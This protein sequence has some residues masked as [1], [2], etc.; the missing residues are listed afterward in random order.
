MIDLQYDRILTGEMVQ[1]LIALSVLAGDPNL[2]SSTHV[3]T[4][5]HS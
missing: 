1:W 3:V 2:V 4:Y 5:K